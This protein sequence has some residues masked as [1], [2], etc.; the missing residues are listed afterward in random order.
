[1]SSS[2]RFCPQCGQ[3]VI[4]KFIKV[5]EPQR[6]FC[7]SCEK[8]HFLSPK[9]AAGVI[10]LY[11]GKLVLSRRDIDPG[12]GLWTYPGGFVEVGETVEQA[13]IREAKEEIHADVQL[14]GLLGVYSYPGI[15]VAV[16]IFRGLS[17]GEK[18]RCGDEVQEVAFFS[19]HEIPWEK[20]AFSSVSDALKDF[21]KV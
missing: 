18:P 3:K 5:G 12:Q 21:L 1:M 10:V 9:L 4:L 19:P 16:V 20:L 6:H 15:G 8:I 14:E 7:E 17:I 2:F 11:D 13:A